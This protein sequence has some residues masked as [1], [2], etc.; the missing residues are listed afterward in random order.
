MNIKKLV[1]DPN[2]PEKSYDYED[3]VDE[4]CN[5][6][7]AEREFVYCNDDEEYRCG[8]CDSL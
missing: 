5:N 3:T 2:G 7:E 1:S 6:C 8:N 4:W